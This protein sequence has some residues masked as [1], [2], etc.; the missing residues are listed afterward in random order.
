MLAQLKYRP[1]E[2][3]TAKKF[4]AVHTFWWVQGSDGGGIFKDIISAGPQTYQGSTTQYLEA[5]VVPESSN[6]KTT[7]QDRGLGKRS[8]KQHLR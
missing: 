5:W 3:P 2:D 6:G 7:E 8:I 1:V 4:S